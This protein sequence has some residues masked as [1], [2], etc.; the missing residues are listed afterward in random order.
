MKSEIGYF[1]L[2]FLI[3][4]MLSTPIAAVYETPFVPSQVIS[5]TFFIYGDADFV[6]HGFPGS[7]TIGDPYLIENFVIIGP[8]SSLSIINT[9]AYYVVRNCY[10]I[11]ETNDSQ[12]IDSLVHLQDSDNG[13][14]ENCRII[15]GEI[16]LSIVEC[17]NIQIYSC[18]FTD[19]KITDI[20]ISGSGEYSIDSCEMEIG[21]SVTPEETEEFDISV[22]N[23]YVGDKELLVYSNTRDQFVNGT[24][25][26]QIIIVRCMN[27][28]IAGTP[29]YNLPYSL[30]LVGSNSS[31]IS[32]FTFENTEYPSAMLYYSSDFHFMNCAFTGEGLRIEG[33]SAEQWIHSFENV[34]VNGMP[35]GY[36]SGLQ[37]V[38]IEGEVYGQLI[39]ADCNNVSVRDITIDEVWTPIYISYSTL[40][41]IEKS[42]LQNYT[43][44]GVT[45]WNSSSCVITDCKIE[46]E[47][48]FGILVMSS[49]NCTAIDCVIATVD[50]GVLFFVA[51]DCLV[52]NCEISGGLQGVLSN[53][54]NGTEIVE[55]Q[56]VD[57]IDGIVFGFGNNL[58]I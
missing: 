35:L 33:E 37:D 49:F 28:S 32:N 11:S 56:I 31:N 42:T 2:V 22:S 25:C 13:R 40:C 57:C 47:A 4:G 18:N 43:Y 17:F 9:D 23:T 15:G 41:T 10:F 34:T 52:Y 26:G 39:L 48:E 29:D 6:F 45:I 12:Y 1:I 20:T 27:M 5:D 36:Y 58:K 55:N 53:R 24:D 8:E 46:A 54:A 3:F 51:N 19:N 16:G 7:G 21:V 14:L 30:Q 50:Y 44:S 38:E